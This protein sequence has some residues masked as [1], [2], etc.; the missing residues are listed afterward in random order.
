M[1]TTVA[2]HQ[3]APP[4]PKPGETCNGCGLCCAV[5]LCPLGRLRFRRTQGPCPALHWDQAATRYVCRLATGKWTRR[6]IAAGKGCD[7]AYEAEA[8]G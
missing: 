7:C 2:L 8:P 3:D 1:E 6:W 4:K 5:T